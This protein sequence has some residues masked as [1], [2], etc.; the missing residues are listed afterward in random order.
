MMHLIGK[1][2][3]II[4]TEM[5]KTAFILLF[6]PVLLNIRCSSENMHKKDVCLHSDHIQ[7]LAFQLFVSR[8]TQ[9]TG[10][11]YSLDAFIS[12]EE[13]ENFFKAVQ[14]KLGSSQVPCRK[15]AVIIG[16][17]ALDFSN[18][19]IANLIDQAFELSNKYDIA[20]GFHVD[21]GMF[22][23][24]RDD[25]WKN[26]DN[27]EWIDWDGTPNSSRYVDWVA[28]R[29]APM[30]CFNAPEVKTAS[31]VFI[32]NIAQSIKSNLAELHTS[33]K[34]YLYAGTIIGWESSLDPDRDT[35]RSSGF[36]ALF[37]KG[38]GP[39]S[40]PE[41]I[42][43]ERVEI[44]H[45]YIEWLAEPLFSAGLPVNKT[46]SHIA[47]M[48][49]EYYNYMLTVNPAFEGKSY[50]QLNN[51]SIPEVAMGK[52]YS[53]GFSTYPQPSPAALF[54]EIY[55]LVGNN[56]WASAEGANILLGMPPAG[57]GY[58][59]ES[60]MARHFNHGCT[61]LNLFA[62]NLRGDPFTNAINDAVE[63]AEALSAYKKFLSGAELKE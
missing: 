31:Q 24:K 14:N 8:G 28:T 26:P 47:F 1:E 39:S 7:Y 21:D 38:Y 11:Y 60:Y 48:S 20:V 45:E 49:R 40:P 54:E 19:D 17:L 61:L 10:E 27:I 51:F 6:A 62:F 29:L 59:M 63:N 12:G 41:D 42:D 23:A 46:Y 30:M 35:Q 50:E 44:L 16:P 32:A 56:T 18:S 43:R 36:H 58:T 53:P 5:K 4:R 57:S 33:H 2:L 34:A 55:Q 9:P 15:T 37:N 13:M 3:Q 52:N 22:W 25:L